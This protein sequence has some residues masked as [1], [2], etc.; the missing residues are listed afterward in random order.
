MLFSG[1]DVGVVGAWDASLGCISWLGTACKCRA[2]GRGTHLLSGS[3][4]S[5]REYG[6][7]IAILLAR[8]Y[9]NIFAFKCLYLSDLYLENTGLD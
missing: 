2:L 4:Q 6:Y 5:G 8:N 7:C 9:Q 1:F 3:R